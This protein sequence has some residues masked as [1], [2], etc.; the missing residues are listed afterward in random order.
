MLIVSLYM[1]CA[2]MNIKGLRAQTA[3]TAVLIN[4]LE[5][6][7]LQKRQITFEQL[8]LLVCIDD[9]GGFRSI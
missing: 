6:G 7:M 3:E 1:S 9:R 4:W 8:V 2:G 5:Q